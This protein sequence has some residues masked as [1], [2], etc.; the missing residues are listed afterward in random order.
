[1]VNTIGALTGGKSQYNET[2][3]LVPLAFLL[4]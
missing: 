1:M 3:V 4:V 2:Q